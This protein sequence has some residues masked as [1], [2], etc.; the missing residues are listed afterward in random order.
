MYYIPYH[1][2]LSVRWCLLALADTETVLV[3]G[4]DGAKGA[5]G[6]MGTKGVSH[7][8]GGEHSEKKIFPISAMKSSDSPMIIAPASKGG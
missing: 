1:I 2:L 8:H 6:A 3:L 7:C 5:K 4:S